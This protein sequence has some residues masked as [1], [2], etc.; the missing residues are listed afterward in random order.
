MFWVV[1][2]NLRNLN[3]DL[4]LGSALRAGHQCAGGPAPPRRPPDPQPLQAR[5]TFMDAKMVET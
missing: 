3:Q 2:Q 5:H 1:G 4:E